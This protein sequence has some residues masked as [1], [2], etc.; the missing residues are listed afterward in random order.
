MN[1]EEQ[2]LRIEQVR[3]LQELGFDVAK[4]SSMCWVTYTSDEEPY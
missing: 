4:H 2:V 1:I 3:E